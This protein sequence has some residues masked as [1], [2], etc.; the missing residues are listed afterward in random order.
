[1]KI[2]TNRPVAQGDMLIIPIAI[3]PSSA[4][5]AQPEGEHFILAHS[6]TGHHHVIERAKAEVYEAADDSFIAY[7]RALA[8]ADIM[9]QRPHDTHETVQL[10]PGLYEIRRQREYVAEGFRKAQD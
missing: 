4:K 1:M 7:V 6:E 10:S 3:I 8:P 9:H 5:A 2:V